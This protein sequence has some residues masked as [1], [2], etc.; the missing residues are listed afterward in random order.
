MAAVFTFGHFL[1][2]GA[3]MIG[4][5]QSLMQRTMAKLRKAK[6]KEYHARSELN[7]FRG[8]YEH[9]QV[10]NPYTNLKNPFENIGFNI[11]EGEA[12]F[13][14]DQ[15]QQQQANALGSLTQVSSNSGA[16][17]RVR[18]LAQMGMDAAHRSAASIGQQESQI[19]LL[20]PQMSAKLDQLERSGRNVTAMFERDKYAK[21]MNMAN[22]DL[23]GYRAD[24]VKQKE[25]GQAGAIFNMD[26]FMDL[27][28]HFSGKD[29]Q[30]KDRDDLIDANLLHQQFMQQQQQQT[31]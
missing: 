7:R 15:F 16:A 14:R 28:G 3:M 20:Q 25:R 5:Q 23:Y 2:A 9:L 27:A 1:G 22:T 17:Q 4:Q 8:M 29:K 10:S 21:L 18:M 19:K 6:R 26:W 24:L 11:N 30:K 12:Q 31:T 13:Q